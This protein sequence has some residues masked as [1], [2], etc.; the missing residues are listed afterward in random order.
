MM[1]LLKVK[2]QSG[3][4]SV[5]N[6]STDPHLVRSKSQVSYK[7]PVCGPKP[8]APFTA[9]LTSLIFPVY[10]PLLGTLF[11]PLPS[12]SSH[13]SVRPILTIL[14][15][16]YRSTTPTQ[17]LSLIQKLL[18]YNSQNFRASSQVMLMLGVQ[19]PHCEPLLHENLSSQILILHDL[20]R[21]KLLQL[22]G[23]PDY[24]KCLLTQNAG[25]I[26]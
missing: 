4:S 20:G 19:E 15:K 10:L 25:P 6:L 13:L 11:L 24:L 14:V 17:N 23:P 9:F 1:I 12:S 16:I 26:P 18:K 2:S 22:Q 3:H 7:K 8:V 21:A 5:Q